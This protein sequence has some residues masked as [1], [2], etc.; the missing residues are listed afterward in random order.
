MAHF[1]N[2]S[3]STSRPSREHLAIC[4]NCSIVL[5]TTRK[6]I[7]LGRDQSARAIPAARR[8]ALYARVQAAL[9]QREQG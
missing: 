9:A 7:A 4:A 2:R 1:T 5:D 8:E 6:T 3:M